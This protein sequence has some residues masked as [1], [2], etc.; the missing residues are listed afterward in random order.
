MMYWKGE[1]WISL[2]SDFSECKA[3]FSFDM[4][5]PIGLLSR[6]INNI[7]GEYLVAKKKY[8]HYLFS[9]LKEEANL[10]AVAGPQAYFRGVRS[11]TTVPVSEG[12][13]K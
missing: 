11:P 9:D 1:Q 3:E 4:V 13:L 12:H 10:P 6:Q 5:L 2:P 8:E 7:K